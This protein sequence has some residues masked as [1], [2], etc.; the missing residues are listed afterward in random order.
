MA[1]RIY[2]YIVTSI[3][4]SG[5]ELRLS[6]LFFLKWELLWVTLFYFTLDAFDLNSTD[7]FGTRIYF[8]TKLK[9]AAL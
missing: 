5:R 8:L 1:R 3:L 6:Y 2:M 4:F 7:P 9:Y